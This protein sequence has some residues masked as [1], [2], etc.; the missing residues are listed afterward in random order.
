MISFAIAFVILFRPYYYM[1][2]G[3]LELEEETGYSYE[4]IKE[5]NDNISSVY[6][7]LN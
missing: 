1:N 4:V 3:I 2:I 7:K 5:F 6:I